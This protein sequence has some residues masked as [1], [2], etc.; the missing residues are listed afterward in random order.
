MGAGDLSMQDY[1]RD[2]NLLDF[3]ATVSMETLGLFF[4][5]PDLDDF[6]HILSIW[7][8]GYFRPKRSLL[9]FNE[10]LVPQGRTPMGAFDAITTRPDFLEMSKAGMETIMMPRLPCLDL[11]RRSGIS[12]MDATAGRSGKDGKPLDPVRQFMIKQ[13]IAK[14]QTQLA[15]IGATEWVP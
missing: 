13:W 3:C 6:E 4:S 1:A 12:F 8:A 7:K 14:I 5:G 15:E 10:H 11:M 9:I 2:L